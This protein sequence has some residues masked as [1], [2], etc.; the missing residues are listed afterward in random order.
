V[1]GCRAARSRLNGTITSTN[2]QEVGGTLAGTNVI[3]GVLN[4]TNGNLEQR[5][6]GDHRQ[7]TAC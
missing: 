5:Q 1:F 6:F 2:L 7:Q 4:W 3:N